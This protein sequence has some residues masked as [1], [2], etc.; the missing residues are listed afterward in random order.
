M[1]FSNHNFLRAAR[2]LFPRASISFC[3]KATAAAVVAAV[4]RPEIRVLE[5]TLQAVAVEE[6]ASSARSWCPLRRAPRTPLQLAAAEP[7]VQVQAEAAAIPE[8]AEVK[9]DRPASVVAA[10]LTPFSQEEMAE[11]E[12]SG[13]PSPKEF[14]E[15][16]EA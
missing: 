16:S 4:D 6:A 2:S 13:P 5:T 3:F 10:F 1:S 7:A 14:L 9:A 12:A 11:W 15:D 8:E